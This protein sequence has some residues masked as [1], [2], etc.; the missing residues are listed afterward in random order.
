MR[1]LSRKRWLLVSGVA[2]VASGLVA[3]LFW[4]RP[5]VPVSRA[6]CERVQVGMTLEEVEAVLGGRAG[7]YRSVEEQPR[8]WVETRAY[9]E[10]NERRVLWEGDDGMFVVTLDTDD[11]VL[12]SDFT[13]HRLTLIDKLRARLGF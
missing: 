1:T 4:P 3:V 11:K 9:N 13:P 5:D 8:L 12:Y 10:R 2:V 6:R 7:D